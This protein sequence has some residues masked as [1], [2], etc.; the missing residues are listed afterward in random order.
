MLTAGIVAEYNPFHNGHKYLVNQTRE[1]GATHVI[2]VMSG[3]AVQ[4]GDCA[5][6]DKYFRANCAV[7]NGVDLVLE[8]P[9]PFSCSSGE[10]FAKSAIQILS[11]LGEN[12]VN[13]LSFGSEIGDV[14][15]LKK[16]SIASSELKD[17]MIV[18]EKLSIGKSYPLSIYES[19]CEVYGKNVGEVLATP[20]STLGVEY[21]KAI[22]ELAPDMEISPVLR[23]S[24]GHHDVKAVDNIASASSIRRLLVEG[25]IVND[26]LPY[27]IDNINGYFIENMQNEILYRLSCAEK[28]ALLSLPD[29][30]E[31]IADR[32]ISSITQMPDT[33]NEFLNL[34]KS[35]NIIMARLRRIIMYLMLDV[36]KQDIKSV[37]YVR[38]LAFNKNGQEILRKC[39][40]SL[41][42]IGTSL[43]KLEKTSD[44]AK[45]IS[46]LEQNATKFQYFC[47]EKKEVFIND[48][49]RKIALIK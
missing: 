37:P 3:A 27:S 16:A 22:S 20:N 15:L 34:C 24:V 38:I 17:S 25:E 31:D 18:R 49:K 8:L 23:K 39:G 48:Y 4:R 12:V 47:K 42:P 36:K 41:L 1:N 43:K 30:N 14:D 11:S 13:R 45:R 7:Q 29:V 40:N 33:L 5:V 9:C 10:V 46:T 28:D 19:V 21:V 32:I 35:K 6:F 2:S 44:Y 26:Y